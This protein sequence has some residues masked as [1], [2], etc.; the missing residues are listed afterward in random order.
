MSLSF[1]F[2]FL[3]FFPLDR[4]LASLP[5]RLLQAAAVVCHREL[6]A[7]WPPGPAEAAGGDSGRGADAESRRFRS[8]R[9]VIIFPIHSLISV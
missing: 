7:D 3:F 1:L 4:H 9:G 6:G 5:V 8:E 2:S